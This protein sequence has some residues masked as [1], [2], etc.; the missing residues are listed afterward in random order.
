MTRDGFEKLQEKEKA[1]NFRKPDVVKTLAKAREMGDLKENGDYRAAKMELSDIDR[2]LRLLTYVI[3]AAHVVKTTKTGIVDIGRRVVISN[4]HGEK[5]NNGIG[6]WE[7]NPLEKK[8][9]PLS[10]TGKPLL[11]KRT[12]DIVTVETPKGQATFKILKI[13][14]Q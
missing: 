12:G 10:P 14:L 6:T 4:Q 1:L 5:T 8:L 9:S 7:A 13:T 11:G 3:S 2:Q